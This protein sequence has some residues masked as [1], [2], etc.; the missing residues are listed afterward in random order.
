LFDYSRTLQL[1]D[2]I[3]E[4]LDLVPVGNSS[5]SV[6]VPEI[7]YSGSSKSVNP[8]HS[9][10]FFK[11]ISQNIYKYASLG[12]RD[13]VFNLTSIGTRYAM[14]L[15]VGTR[16]FNNSAYF[17]S[18]SYE[19][20]LL[21]I[22]E[23]SKHISSGVRVIPLCETIISLLNNY[24]CLHLLPRSLDRNIWLLD[25]GVIKLFS[26][27]LA[28]NTLNA[29]PDLEDRDSL[30]KYIEYVHLNT[31]RH[32]FT[33]KSLELGVD[34]NHIATYMGQN[35]AGSEQFGIYSTLDVKNYFDVA[36]YVTQ[37][38]ASEHGIKD[39]L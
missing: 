35:I 10:K 9:R 12:D 7:T 3:S 38:I 15:L 6:K 34:A 17:D 18:C 23:K 11:A 21:I 8:Y 4:M 2:T 25:D 5:I 32:C 16:G 30:E 28:S 14:S 13:T 31:G 20:G 26:K 39:Q 36:T 22:N 33:Q 19:L 1:D 29:I 24:E 27:K 37:T